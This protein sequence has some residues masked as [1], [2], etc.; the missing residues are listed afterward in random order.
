MKQLSLTERRILD[1]IR[2]QPGVSRADVAQQLGL[3]PA[4]LTKVATRFVGDG[5]LSEKRQRNQTQRGQPA[6][7]LSVRNR[8]VV[9]LGLSLSTDGVCG[10][11]QDLTGETVAVRRHSFDWDDPASAVQAA[12]AVL[13][14]IPVWDAHI[15]GIT[16]WAPGLPDASGELVEVTPSQNALDYSRLRRDLQDRLGIDVTLES[17]ASAIHDLMWAPASDAVIFKLFLDF[18]V[19]GSLIDGTRVF[20]GAFGQACNIGALVPD[21]GPRPSL[22]DLARAL[23]LDLRSLDLGD[24]ERRMDAGDPQLVDWVATRGAQLSEPLSVVVQLI[25][26]ASI[27]VGGLFPVNVIEALIGHI[28]LTRHDVPG[29]IALTKPDI[30]PATIAGPDSMA[31]AAASVPLYNA[32]VPV[33]G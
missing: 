33:V 21:S 24:I 1:Q 18:G 20:R 5:V 29:R 26:P 25:N 28:D 22:P 3:S 14:A 11:A 7:K 4:L 19:G 31:I 32:C 27:V 13:R 16:I 12:E 9:G 10:A 15:A 8:S 17:K 6:L 2:R 30:R 23:G